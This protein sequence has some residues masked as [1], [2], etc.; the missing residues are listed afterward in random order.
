MIRD[1]NMRAIV[2][3]EPIIPFTDRVNELHREKGVST[4][5]VIGGS[6]EY[7]ACADTVILMEDYLPRVITKEVAKLELPVRDDHV[8]PARWSHS[9]RMIPKKTAQPF[10]YFQ[11][12]E[13]ENEKKIIL[14]EY[15]ADIT[16]LT[17]LISGYQLNTLACV[18]EH[19]IA[20]KEADAA[21]LIEKA[22]IYTKR[23]LQEQ[24]TASLVPDAAQ[25]FYEDIR[26]ID[27]FCC[28]N[29]MRGLEFSS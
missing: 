13:T 17:A 7:L 20:D 4:I 24:D 21:E 19:L 29:R 1:K 8:S 18:M 10:L 3:N 12:V 5:L 16:L 22:E 6:G 15:T 26:P 11:K 9:R 14:D 27:A 2:K 23:M 28:A 25:R